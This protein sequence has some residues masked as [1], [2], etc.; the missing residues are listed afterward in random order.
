MSKPSFDSKR[1]DELDDLLTLAEERGRDRLVRFG[2]DTGRVW[3]ATVH[4]DTITDKP[5]GR[6]ASSL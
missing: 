1:P 5:S 4:P 6:V 2:V 3:S